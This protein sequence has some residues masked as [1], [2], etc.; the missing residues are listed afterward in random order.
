MSV[1]GKPLEQNTDDA[2]LARLTSLLEISE[3]KCKYW[4]DRL[5]S[6]GDMY[7]DTFGISE[8]EVQEGHSSKLREQI[9]RLQRNVLKKNPPMSPA[10]IARLSPDI[11]LRE[12]WRQFSLQMYLREYKL[13][14]IIPPPPEVR[15]VKEF[16]FSKELWNKCTTTVK[17]LKATP[18]DGAYY[19][20]EKITDYLVRTLNKLGV[21]LRLEEF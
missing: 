4:L 12:A 20:G 14:E 2:E 7:A 3:R 11:Q 10:K 16:V 19:D 17:V 15:H 6:Q 1:Y 18:W 9:E 5:S 21:P 13:G 8:Y